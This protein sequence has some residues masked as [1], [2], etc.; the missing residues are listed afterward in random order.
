MDNIS[1]NSLSEKDRKIIEMGEIKWGRYV[2]GGIVGTYPIGMGLG[3]VIQG[4][5][6]SRGWI[7]TVGELSSSFIIVVSAFSCLHGCLDSSGPGLV[8]NIG[9][10]SYL[11]LRIW[12][13]VDVW[14]APA[15]HNRRYRQ[16]KKKLDRSP[17]EDISLFIYPKEKEYIIVGLQIQ[18]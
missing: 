17:G 14:V 1:L 13:A 16:I 11:S 5:Y 12:E 8:R 7:F 4:R 2:L 10:A 15:I 6:R 9:L 3:H 18:F